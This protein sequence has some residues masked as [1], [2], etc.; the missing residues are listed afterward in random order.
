VDSETGWDP[1]ADAYALVGSSGFEGPGVRHVA[2]QF[3]RIDTSAAPVCAHVVWRNPHHATSV[4]HP[5]QYVLW[6]ACESG[7]MTRIQP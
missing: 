1:L 3:D 7:T 4:G 2:Y 6:S 5:F